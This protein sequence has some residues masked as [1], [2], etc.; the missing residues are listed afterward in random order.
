MRKSRSGGARLS[1]RISPERLDVV[2][3][4]RLVARNQNQSIFTGLRN[5]HAI[6]RIAMVRRQ[7]EHSER[8]PQLDRKSLSPQIDHLAEVEC[9][10]GWH[11]QLAELDLD[12]NLPYRDRAYP[13]F[14]FG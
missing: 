7:V 8:V 1:P 14:D 10:A 5:Q 6:E 11:S 3:G 13:A 12:R 2:G 4:E 9:A